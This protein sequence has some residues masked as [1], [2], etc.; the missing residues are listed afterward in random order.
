MNLT[1]SQKVYVAI[2]AAAIGAFLVDRFV[3]GGEG[4]VKQA[5]AAEAAAI[6]RPLSIASTSDETK[7]PF[8]AARLD[9]LKTTHPA[10][11]RR[12]RDAFAP[13]AAWQETLRPTQVRT[14]LP[15]PVSNA[16][17][18]PSR[19]SQFEAAHQLK[20]ILHLDDGGV[21]LVGNKVIGIGQTLDGF[22]LIELT[23]DAAVFDLQGQRAELRLAEGAGR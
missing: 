23:E 1:K 4:Q 21:A 22:E 19:V 9:L 8:I 7:G 6:D 12:I 17:S 2:L 15:E 16:T 20:S 5:S 3:L 11:L 14:D 18:Q 10:S 13:S